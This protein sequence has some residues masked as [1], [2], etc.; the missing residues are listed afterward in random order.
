MEQGYLK[1]VAGGK[2][3]PPNAPLTGGTTA[4][5]AAAPAPVAAGGHARAQAVVTRRDRS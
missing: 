2:A 4:A 3:V 5:T 1:T